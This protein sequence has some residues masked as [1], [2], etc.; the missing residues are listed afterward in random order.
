[1]LIDGERALISDQTQ[2]KGRLRLSLPPSLEPWWE[3]LSA[4]QQ[5]YPDIQLQVYTSDRRIDMIEDGID[6]AMRI[7][8][9]T[10]ESMVARRMLAYRHILVASPVLLA[11]LGL[12]DKVADL[13]HYPCGA[14]SQD[15]TA[16]WQLGEEVFKADPIIATNDYAHLRSRALAGDLVTELPPF[17]AKEAI[18]NKQLVA[19]LGKHPFP[20]M[21]INLLY[22]SHRHPSNLVRTYLDFAQ[23]HIQRLM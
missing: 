17:M 13:H 9:I 3:V 11:R 20:E 18:R 1:M 10:H 7:G 5:R 19:L 23:Q 12:P 2:L 14:W 4:F 22:P 8:R 6:V 16:T 21:E 15:A